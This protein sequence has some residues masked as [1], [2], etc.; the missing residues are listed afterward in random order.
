MNDLINWLRETIAAGGPD[1]ARVWAVGRALMV[2]ALLF[3]VVLFVSRRVRAAVTKRRTP[4]AGF[5]AGKVILYLGGGLLLLSTLGE[6][7]FDVSTLLGAAGVAGVALGFAAQS[8]VSNLI[9]GFF[10]V[11]ERP[12]VVGDTVRLGDVTGEV[13]SIDLLSVKLRTF[14]N[15]LVR[16]PS[17][18]VFKGN[19]V[20]MTRYPT[21]RLDINVGVGYGEDLKRVGQVLLDVARADP[22]CLQE[23]PP[24]VRFDKFGASSVDFVL[25]LWVSTAEFWNV[26]YTLPVEIHARFRQ[27]GISIPFPQTTLSA[28]PD[29]P[30]LPV[31]V[32]S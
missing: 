4:Q 2:A 27:E 9:S 10:L 26:S 1:A 7:G 28:L 29:S 25:A 18:A 22:R 8:T 31:R 23:P 11:I 16:M 24:S 13:L 14:D 15:R 6:L 19:V 30:P 20:N 21:R 5:L 32:V 12:F 3:P 17:E